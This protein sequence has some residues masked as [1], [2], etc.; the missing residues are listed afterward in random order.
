MASEVV[1]CA[2]CGALMTPWP[3]LAWRL[4]WRWV[5][6]KVGDG[7]GEPRTVVRDIL[8]PEHAREALAALGAKDRDDG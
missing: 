2:Q 6:V 4:G 8:C 3:D 1:R 5:E 7:K